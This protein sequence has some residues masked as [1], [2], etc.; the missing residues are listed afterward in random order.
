LDPIETPDPNRGHVT[1]SAPPTTEPAAAPVPEPP[2]TIRE[3]L[4][5]NSTLLFL[6]VLILIGVYKWLGPD[7]MWTAFLVAVGLGLVIFIHELGHFLVAKWCDV[8]VETFS[9]GFGPP[10]PGCQ[11]KRGETTYQ[12]AVVPLGGYVKM[13]GENPEHEDEESDPRSFKNKKVWQRMLIISAGVFMNLVLGCVC[14]AIAYSHG[15]EEQPGTISAID[16][17]SPIWEKGNHTGDVILQIGDVKNPT[18]EKVR[19]E[20]ALSDQKPIRFIYKHYPWSGQPQIVDTTIEPRLPPDGLIPVI[21]FQ[22]PNSLTLLPARLQKQLGSPTVDGTPAAKAGFKFDDKIVGM[23]DPE[24]DGQVTPLHNDPRYPDDPRPDY[25]DYYRRLKLLAGKPIT[26]QVDREGQKVDVKVEPAYHWTFGLRMK[27]G[28]IVAVRGPAQA[29]GDADNRI[30]PRDKKA[31]NEGDTITQIEVATKDGK[32]IRWMAE[33]SAAPPADVEERDLDPLK[34]PFDLQQWADTISGPKKV[35]VTVKGKVKQAEQQAKPPFTLDWDDSYRFDQE[36]PISS[37][38][39]LPTL[40]IAYQVSNVVEAAAPGYHAELLESKESFQF[41]KSDQILA[42]CGFTKDKNTEELKP[43]TK[44]IFFFFT[45]FAWTEL[46]QGTEWTTIFWNVQ[47]GHTYDKVLVKVRQGNEEKEV[48]LTGKDDTSWPL[49]GR[50]IRFMPQS[51]PSK[52]ES[53]GDAVGMGFTRTFM[54]IRL[55]YRQLSA[56]ITGGL[57]WQNMSGPIGIAGTAYAAAETDLNT[58]ILFLGIISVNLAVV[59]FLPIPILDG[60]HMVFLIYEGLRGKPASQAV[61]AFANYAGLAL[62]ASLM[63]FVICLDVKRYLF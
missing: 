8:H 62:I 26:F 32:K 1:P 25:F 63:L 59:N 10:L 4:A 23:T 35:V 28:R 33:R 3:W 14:F 22:P 9:I 44:T 17:A 36:I 29:A 56:L 6:M 16:N 27:M 60:G 21:G 13:V 12:I 5:R 43:R 61:Y 37:A 47:Q 46:K 2:P 18:F 11:F 15:V 45:R 38:V 34:L 30:T 52:A 40:G 41:Q 20:V 7:G 57:S 53:L 58:L 48:V 42:F 54:Y 55:I 31:E 19:P 50:G 51:Q 49:V 39:A 24:K